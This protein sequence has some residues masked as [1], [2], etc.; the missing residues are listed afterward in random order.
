ME[1]GEEV[2][3]ASVSASSAYVWILGLLD[4][5]G[6][7]PKGDKHHRQCPAHHDAA[8]SL[9]VAAG[10]GGRVLLQCH[11]GCTVDEI[12]SALHLG[13]RH[14]FTPSPLTPAEHVEVLG[15]FLEFPA[16]RRSSGGRA[17]HRREMQLVAVHDYGDFQLLRYRHPTT[18]EK[19]LSW[20]RRDTRGVWIPGLGGKSLAELPL[21]QE[22][23]V[24]MA[25][26]A[27]EAV[28][29]VE[30]ESSVDA[31]THAGAYA[32]T[33]AGGASTPQLHRLVEVLD[34]ASV[35]V[36]PDRDPAGLRCGEIVA[37]AL[38]AAGA[39]VAVLIPDKEGEDARD[40]LN[41]MACQCST[42]SPEVQP[43]HPLLRCRP[44]DL[45]HRP[46]N[47]R[48]TP[49][50]WLRANRESTERPHHP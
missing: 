33:W 4:V 2:A 9:S 48:L 28:I 15:S 16:L 35:L 17:G 23:Q 18:G 11:A 1:V 3:S 5:V 29:V 39:R 36:V 13:K 45:A 27:S 19:E 20:E 37:D 21:Y 10:D 41:R 7:G 32:T 38:K 44:A 34:H 22:R 46:R 12:L 8:P 14:L 24:R 50:T 40:L 49:A 42:V 6:S 30:S 31:L 43:G 25:V 47:A 26:A